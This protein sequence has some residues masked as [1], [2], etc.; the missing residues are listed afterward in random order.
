MSEKADFTDASVEVTIPV[1][2]VNTDNE[3][4]DKH[5]MGEDFFNEEKYPKIMFK[6]ESLTKVT[7]SSKVN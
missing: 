7:T 4:R 1:S 6:S 3:K 2:S 5:L